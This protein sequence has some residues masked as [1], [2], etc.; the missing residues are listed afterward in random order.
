MAKIELQ[1]VHSNIAMWSQ[2][3]RGSDKVNFS[4]LTTLTLVQS[5]NRNTS[6][7]IMLQIEGT[8]WDSA[9]LNHSCIPKITFRK[10]KYNLELRPHQVLEPVPSCTTEKYDIYTLIQNQRGSFFFKLWKC[11]NRS[12]PQLQITR[13][14][15]H[16]LWCWWHIFINKFHKKTKTSIRPR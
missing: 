15:I 12:N 11:F 1:D 10:V 2:D 6:Y 5:N 7:S 4:F 8:F 9:Y 3:I 14:N 16:Y 13:K